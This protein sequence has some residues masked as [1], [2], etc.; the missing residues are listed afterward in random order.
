MA[1]C[2][3]PNECAS[4]PLLIACHGFG[5][6]A[7]HKLERSRYLYHGKCGRFHKFVDKGRKTLTPKR[8]DSHSLL[9]LLKPHIFLQILCL[10][11]LPESGS[12]VARTDCVG[13]V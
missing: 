8:L 13:L 10:P 5:S 7:S 1:V 12:D 3:Y 11:C 6:G 2:V 4:Y 9:S